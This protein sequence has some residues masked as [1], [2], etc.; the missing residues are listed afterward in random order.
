MPGGPVNDAYGPTL[1]EL[2]TQRG[3]AAPLRRAIL[4]AL[5]LAGLV[6]AYLLATNGD[7]AEREYVERSGVQFNLRYPEQSLSR[8]TP[9][10]GE[11][12][13]LER[14]REGR[15]VQSFAVSPL[16]LPAYSGDPGGFLPAFATTVVDQLRR[17]YQ[18]FELVQE[19]KARV[20]EAVAYN[21]SFRSGVPGK[22]VYGRVVLLPE[23]RPG[24]RRGLTLTLEATREAGVSNP[25][26]VGV[27]GVIKRP[28]RTFRLGT[29]HP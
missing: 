3:I 11:I 21:I 29:E 9:H 24:A 6:L 10:K 26:E 2:L 25:L 7:R 20:N 27:R 19:N 22:R 15:F 8:V 13:R 28:F 4:G 1:P 5:V 17:R 23:Q 14:R 12:L 16:A 18:G